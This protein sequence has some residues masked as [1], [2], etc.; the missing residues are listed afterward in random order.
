MFNN[1]GRRT[2][3]KIDGATITQYEGTRVQTFSHTTNVISNSHNVQGINANIHKST[4]HD[5]DAQLLRDANDIASYQATGQFPSTMAPALISTQAAEMVHRQYAVM[6]GAG[7]TSFTQ[8]QF[9]NDNVHP[10]D[11]PTE[12]V[13]DAI[14]DENFS[15]SDEEA[16]D[17]DEVQI[18]GGPGIHIS[19]A[20]LNMATFNS[21]QGGM[22]PLFDGLIGSVGLIASANQGPYKPGQ[23]TTVTTTMH[24][25]NKFQI[26]SVTH[27]V[28]PSRGF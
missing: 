12:Q 2:K 15:D 1:G 25:T 5:P 7:V 26:G 27:T 18:Q 10:M 20:S 22:T 9:E 23:T 17:A 16:E 8:M 6:H 24:S 3:V 11:G 21:N 4:I 28:S 13:L 14:F 19:G